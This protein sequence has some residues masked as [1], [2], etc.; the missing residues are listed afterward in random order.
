VAD[1][2][3][4]ATEVPKARPRPFTGADSDAVLLGDCAAG[5]IS[6]DIPLSVVSAQ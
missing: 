2:A 1:A 5:L 6:V 3:T 4:P